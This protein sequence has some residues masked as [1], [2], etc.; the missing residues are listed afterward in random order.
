[1]KLLEYESKALFAARGVP[2]PKS[3]GVIDTPAK[4]AGAIKKLGKG[5]YVLKAQVLA[6]GR[7][8]AGGIKVA[9]TLIEAKAYAKAMIGMELRTHQTGGHGLEVKE[10]LV[11]EA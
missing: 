3:G 11:E 5:P 10:V 8:K 4:I 7:G 6:G 2:V 1:M 9:K